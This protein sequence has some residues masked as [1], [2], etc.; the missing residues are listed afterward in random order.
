MSRIEEALRRAR[1]SQLDEPAPVPEPRPDPVP[2]AV[3]RPYLVRETVTEPVA[4]ETVSE[5]VIKP[6]VSEPVI[7]PTVSERVVVA[8][9]PPAE[10]KPAEPT[11][12]VEAMVTTPPAPR[13]RKKVIEEAHPEPILHSEPHRDPRSEKLILNADMPQAVTE[14]YR[15]AAAALHQLQ[16]DRGMKVVMIASALAG[17]GKTVTA[18]NIALTLSES[19]KRRVLLIDADLRRPSIHNAFGTPNVTGLS[20]ALVAERPQKLTIHEVS[21]HLSVLVAGRPNPDPMSS[22]S[23][24]R[25]R[26]IID[27][28]AAMFDWVVIDTPPVGLLADAKLLVEM[29]QAVVLVIGAGQTPFRAIERAV[30]AIDRKKIAGVILNR[31]VD[32]PSGYHDYDYYSTATGAR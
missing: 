16:L 21:S 1:L 3:A 13:Q 31:V 32:H 22:L 11:P 30:A 4:R 18:S 8:A 12:I 9:E 5:P 19:F 26:T 15:K 27:E 24:D 17:E 25:M 10:V 28:A 7:K 2:Q 29:V 20:D 23:S 14:Q 6:T